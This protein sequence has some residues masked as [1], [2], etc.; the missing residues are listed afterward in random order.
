MFRLFCELLP[1]DV[2]KRVRCWLNPTKL[3]L[4]GA[5]RVKGPSRVV[6][7]NDRDVEEKDEN[8]LVTGDAYCSEPRGSAES[9]EPVE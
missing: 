3:V 7:E 6:V 5:R 1:H 9:I 8:D 4:G 2:P